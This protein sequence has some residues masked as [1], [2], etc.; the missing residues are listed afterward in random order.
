MAHRIFLDSSAFVALYNQDDRF[1]EMS[2]ALL[3]NLV[4]QNTLLLTSDYVIDE[5]I[6]ALRTRANHDVATQ[7][8]SAYRELPMGLCGIYPVYFPEALRIFKRYKDKT[9][10]FTDCASFSY[11]LAHNIDTAFTFDHH[12]AQFGFIVLPDR[13]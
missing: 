2:V 8:A 3:D 13:P 1:H 10:S 6:T 4:R 7:F 9:Y 5:V 11:M 12:F